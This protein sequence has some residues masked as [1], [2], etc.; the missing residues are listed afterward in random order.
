MKYNY[1]VEGN[2]E[3]ALKTIPSNFIDIVIT[4]PPYNVAHDYD[5][6]NDNL[7]VDKYW[8]IM[9]E[10][11]AEIFRV[12]KEDGRICLNVPFAIKNRKTKKV[13][14]LASKYA[15]LL[16]NLG[17]NDFEWITWHKGK[18]INHF[19][20]NNT[21]WGSW[22]SPSSPSFRPM[23]EVVL[24][25]Y[26][27]KKRMI[28]AKDAI[29]IN[30]E[31]FKNWTK[32]VWYFDE[33][34]EL[35][36]E[37]LITVPNNASKKNHPAPYPRELIKRLLKMYSYKDSIVLDPFNGIGTTS[38]M[39]EKL[40]RKF[41]GIDQSKLYCDLAYEKLNKDNTKRVTI[42]NFFRI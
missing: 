29:D 35:Y 2:S 12:L 13:S 30:A 14:F 4:S 40:G 9:K 16:N 39:S 33:K 21:A 38:I 19:Q 26:K 42:D 3:Q 17:F 41:I 23:G 32:N 28:R 34:Q 36:Y 10:I 27:N 8:E 11:F 15:E 22:K 7:D 20:G 37:N 31:E 18:N 5:N 24:V 6:Y 1:I 25:F